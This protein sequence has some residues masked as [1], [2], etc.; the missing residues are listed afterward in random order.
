MSKVQFELMFSP[1]ISIKGTQD[2]IDR[3]GS[4]PSFHYDEITKV[5]L[6]ATGHGDIQT[7]LSLTIRHTSADGLE[8]D[9]NFYFEDIQQENISP[10]EECNICLQLSFSYVDELIRVELDA[11]SGFA[12]TFLCRDIRAQL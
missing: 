8:Q 12:A 2:V 3:L 1:L 6:K 4:F 5:H 11:V 10:A 7:D 9:V